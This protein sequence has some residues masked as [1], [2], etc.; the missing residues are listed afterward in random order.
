MSEWRYFHGENGI[1]FS[2]F[3]TTDQ[4][5]IL[6]LLQNCIWDDDAMKKA[7][8][9]E[10]TVTVHLF[11]SFGR[12]AGYGEPD[13]LLFVGEYLIFVELETSGLEKSL[14]NK[15]FTGQMKRFSELGI[16]L[17]KTGIKK[18]L[19]DKKFIGEDGRAFGGRKST[20]RVFMQIKKTAW[21]VCLLSVLDEKEKLSENML[22]VLR[23]KIRIPAEV[24]V[25]IISY[26][27]IC[28]MKNKGVLNKVIRHVLAK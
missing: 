3:G 6:R 26:N 4:K 17:M 14:G 11:P 22:A 25:G 8:G 24:S 27:K 7:L 18:I 28:R 2:L 9:K 5:F 13:A 23:E 19:K 20:R 1:T 16:Q 15:C 21:R 12:N 10:K